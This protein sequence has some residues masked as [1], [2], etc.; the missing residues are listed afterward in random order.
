MVFA[1]HNLA[2][3]NS[4]N[5]FHLVICRNVLI[6]F[7]QQLQNKVINLLY[8]SLCPFGFLGLGNKESL[9]FTD[10]R[11]SFTELDKRERIFMKS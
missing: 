5:E 4:F 2:C 7:N 1:S 6:Y 9:L 8:N 3:D 11:D 10:K